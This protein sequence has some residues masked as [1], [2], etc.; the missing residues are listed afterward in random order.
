MREKA[1]GGVLSFGVSLILIFI[2]KM[3]S[4][5]PDAVIYVL[6]VIALILVS[7]AIYQ[8]FKDRKTNQG[9][10]KVVTAENSIP[11]LRIFGQV[12]SI[13]YGDYYSVMFGNVKTEGNAKVLVKAG[14]GTTSESLP[15]TQFKLEI[16]GKEI[17]TEF[18]PKEVSKGSSW[19]GF[20]EVP[21]EL[22]IKDIAARLFARVGETRY[23]SDEFP[24]PFKSIGEPKP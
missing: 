2:D 22:Q 4:N 16:A 21:K 7:W 1:I 23:D 10:N 12:E 20:F 6:L 8:Y 17:P 14:F 11:A 5:M 24:L 13:D 19:E 18:P 3:V 15:I 9:N